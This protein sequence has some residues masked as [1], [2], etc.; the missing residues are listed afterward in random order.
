MKNPNGINKPPGIK[1]QPP[2]PKNKTLGPLLLWLL[3]IMS[4]ISLYRI[5]TQ[6]VQ[7][8]VR[9]LSYTEFYQMARSNSETGQIQSAMKSEDVI[10]GQLSDGTRYVVNVPQEDEGLKA[11]AQ[12]RSPGHAHSETLRSEAHHG[13]ADRLLRETAHQRGSL[14][15]LDYQPVAN[16]PSRAVPP[17][18]AASVSR[19]MLYAWH[20]TADHC[21]ALTGRVRKMAPPSLATISCSPPPSSATTA[22]GH[23]GQRVLSRPNVRRSTAGAS[24]LARIAKTMRPLG[25]LRTRSCARAYT[26][27]QPVFCCAR[28]RP[29]W[30]ASPMSEHAMPTHTLR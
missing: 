21:S 26:M 10:E 22:M 6:T 23:R 7:G 15:T 8:P 16:S 20:S 13:S 28:H 5:G 4:F 1:R 18:G 24:L 14:E 9:K 11:G 27:R 2:R 19:A 25:A 29:T 30:S 17:P 12:V 3:I